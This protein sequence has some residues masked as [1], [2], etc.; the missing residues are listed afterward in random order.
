MHSG[1]R[2]IYEDLQKRLE[3]EGHLI[4]SE[5]IAL[6]NA[7]PYGLNDY[8]QP[9]SCFMDCECG[10]VQAVKEHGN[11]KLHGLFCAG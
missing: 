1:V 11:R 2:E 7:P 8:G 10:S 6:L 9:L 3:T 5:E 4:F